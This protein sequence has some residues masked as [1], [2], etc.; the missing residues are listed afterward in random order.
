RAAQVAAEIAIGEIRLVVGEWIARI[1]NAVAIVEIQ[2]AAEAVGAGAGEN[3]DAAEAQP[4]VFG[5]EGILVDADLANGF[6]GRQVA[7]AETIDIDGAAVGAGAGSGQRL[8][9]VRKVVRIVGQ[10]RQIFPAQN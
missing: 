4:V 2:G 9:R 1:E 10:G 3:L 5:G 6:L 7:A 8:Q